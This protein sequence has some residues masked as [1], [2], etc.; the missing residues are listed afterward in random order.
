[1]QISK[2]A[3]EKWKLQ[4]ILMIKIP[5][6]SRLL[7]NAVPVVG[8]RNGVPVVVLKIFLTSSRRSLVNAGIGG[9]R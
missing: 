4:T 9:A 6:E 1:M 2:D 3:T 8:M 7:V 5:E